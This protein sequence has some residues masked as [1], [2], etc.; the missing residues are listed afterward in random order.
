MQRWIYRGARSNRS[1]SAG[2]SPSGNA[3]RD[4]IHD[5]ADCSAD[6]GDYDAGKSG[7][8]PD[9]AASSEWGGRQCGH[10]AAAISCEPDAGSNGSG[11]EAG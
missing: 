1:R 3:C 6:S 8:K 7:P 4:A 5:Y 10:D 11:R 9:D 2:G